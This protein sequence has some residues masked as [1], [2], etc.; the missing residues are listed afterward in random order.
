MTNESRDPIE[1]TP[2]VSVI[3]PTTCEAARAMLL[4]R[5][6][7]SVTMQEGVVPEVLLVCNGNRQDPGLLEN[8]KE[9]AGV[10]IVHQDEGNVSKARHF[11]V[12]HAT[13]GEFFCFL[14]DDDELLPGCLHRRLKIMAVESDCDVVCTN[15][16][17]H[18]SGTETP[19]V[20][21]DVASTIN[22]DLCGTFLRQNWF[23]S[24]ASMFRARK[25]EP[26]MFDFHFKYFE[27][28]YLFFL[29]ISKHR[30]IVFD[31]SITYRKYEDNPLSVSKS[32]D[33]SLAYPAF[34]QELQQLNLAKPV[35][36]ALHE[37]YVAALNSRSN[38]YRQQGRW[39]DA[40]RSHIE[41][42]A[43]GGL[44]Y[45]PYTRHLLLPRSKSS[46]ADST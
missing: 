27:W 25:I 9:L 46:I 15:G 2:Q 24:P 38:L 6:I 3:I 8:L 39:L 13:K 37:K 42:L 11:G 23:A 19:L 17:I 20:S 10:R 31:D 12:L 32:I 45:V 16:L 21:S 22:A 28:A 36:A 44:R 30:K 35:K 40:W 4:K 18:V 5:A 43:H 33:Y 41:C 29:L 1:T 7:A 34:L 14:D 26:G